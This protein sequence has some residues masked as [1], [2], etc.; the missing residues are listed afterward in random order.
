MLA[1]AEIL[2]KEKVKIVYW[3]H[4]DANNHVILGK[5]KQA[6]SDFWNAKPMV[7]SGVLRSTELMSQVADVLLAPR[8][9]LPDYMAN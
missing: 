3:T 4:K 8:I 2:P 9:P 1:I 5:E 7:E 6:L